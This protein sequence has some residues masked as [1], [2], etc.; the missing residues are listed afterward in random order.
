[1]KRKIAIF[2]VL[3]MFITLFT[4]CYDSSVDKDIDQNAIKEIDTSTASSIGTEGVK[5]VIRIE[6]NG[7]GREAVRTEQNQ[8]ILN[9]TQPAKKLDWSLERENLNKR[10]ERWNDPNKLSY[11]YL[12][13]NDG[14]I[15]AYFP[16]KGK[17]S[18]VNSKLT[19]TS[20]LVEGEDYDNYSEDQR[21]AGVVESPDMDGSY[22]SNGDAVFFFLSDD[23]YMEW[24]GKYLLC[25][26]PIKLT[27]EPKMLY[28][29]KD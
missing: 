29:V 11:I 15:M 10:L 17:V 27:Q 28:E 3:S 23:T 8:N 9:K 2:I 20:Q 18:S 26:N 21:N 7:Y 14:V 1:M 19:T 4:G 13:S 25:D 22:G 24:N 16:I 6:N 5:D 12:L